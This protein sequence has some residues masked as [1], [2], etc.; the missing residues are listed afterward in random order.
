MPFISPWGRSVTCILDEEEKDKDKDKDNKGE[1]EDE[2]ED[3]DEEKDNIDQQQK[4]SHPGADQLHI[5]SSLLS[6]CSRLATIKLILPTSI[7]R[8]SWT[9][10]LPNDH[11]ETKL[12]I[13]FK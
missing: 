13:N 5:S 10:L 8:L 1:D 11:F 3:E 2:D 7:F 12:R 4:I 6:I 9:N